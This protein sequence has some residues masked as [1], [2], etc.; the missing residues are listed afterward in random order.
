MRSSKTFLYL[1]LILLVSASTI[2]TVLAQDG[3][4][5]PY[6]GDIKLQQAWY[7]Q[8]GTYHGAFDYIDGVID[9][10]PWLPFTVVAC[11]AGTARY[12][13]EVNDPNNSGKGN[14]VSLIFQLG[15]HSYQMKYCHLESSPLPE[16]PD[17]VVVL[18]QALG[19]TGISGA[20]NDVNHLHYL[21]YQ[22]GV[23]FDPYGIASGEGDVKKRDS[24]WPNAPLGANHIFATNP[25]SFVPIVDVGYFADGWHTDGKSQAILDCFIANGGY[26]TFGAP[27]DKGHSPYAYTL[28]N[29][30][31]AQDFDKAGHWFQIIYNPAPSVEKAYSVHGQILTF[32]EANNGYVNYGPPFTNEI[33]KKLATGPEGTV[34]SFAQPGDDLIYQ[35]F[36]DPNGTRKTIAFNTRTGQTDHY[37]LATFGFNG[38]SDIQWFIQSTGG[39]PGADVAWP[40]ILQ[41]TPTG[42]WVTVP[43]WY[44]FVQH[45]N[46]APDGNRFGG[47]IAQLHE[48]NNQ[49]ADPSGGTP[50]PSPAPVTNL[51]TSSV[52][53]S[54]VTLT[55]TD[56]NY[57][58]ASPYQVSRDG[59]VIGTSSITSYQDN[60]VATGRIYS[61]SVSVNNGPES[62]PITVSVPVSGD[63]SGGY[64][65]P[66]TRPRYTL[67]STP[68]GARYRVYEGGQTGYMFEGTTPSFIP[69]LNAGMT[70]RIEYLTFDS[71]WDTTFTTVEGD[72]KVISGKL[73]TDPF[74]GNLLLNHSFDDATIEAPWY[75]N[76]TAQVQGN[77]ADGPYCCMVRIHQQGSPESVW[78]RQQIPV[79]RGQRLL[80][81][82]YVRQQTG[83]GTGRVRLLGSDGTTSLGWENGE[84]PIGNTWKY[85]VYL[86]MQV[87]TASDEEA[88]FSFEIGNNVPQ[89][90]YFDRV[91]VKEDV[92][93]KIVANGGFE[94]GITMPWIV[95][96]GNPS[97]VNTPGEAAEGGYCFSNQISTAGTKESVSLSQRIKL[98]NGQYYKVSFWGKASSNRA[99]AV[100]CAGSE[101]SMSLST[102]W[103]EFNPVFLMPQSGDSLSDVQFLMGDV[104]STV[105][106]DGIAVD[107]TSVLPPTNL[108]A[109]GTFETGDL[110]GW[111]SYSESGS[112]TVQNGGAAEG[113]YCSKVTVGST[114][115]TWDASISQRIPVT[116][117]EPRTVIFWGKA[118]S[119]R[120]VYINLTQYGGAWAWY[121]WWQEVPLTTNWQRFSFSL[122]P[123]ATDSNADFSIQCGDQTATV[124]I[125]SVAVLGEGSNPTPPPSG[126]NLL[127]NAGFESGSFSPWD[128]FSDSGTATV[129]NATAGEGTYSAKFTVNTAGNTWDASVSHRIPVEANVSYIV[130][131]RAKASSNR[132]VYI[133]LTE[134][135]GDWTWYGWW[136]EVPVTTVWQE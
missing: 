87:V 123:N 8:D 43:G 105:Y 60:A 78:L 49:F 51:A 107:T 13:R 4:Y 34:W 31:T 38:T 129:T 36:G 104:V 121:G 75:A 63:G 81:G 101:Q 52:T 106:L 26:T 133:N 40:K 98:K 45:E 90:Y 110:S 124:W 112:V 25:P 134:Y 95:S 56:P 6:S 94:S 70:I 136:Q 113:D 30:K 128:G 29:G 91:V 17:V 61:Y 99:L 84:F 16:G 97:F 79:I 71:S 64:N 11:H 102:A 65:D 15:G 93:G 122:T 109:N 116:A 111:D 88:L 86:P 119:N 44:N 132:M 76:S 72:T 131:L 77:A 35:K 14:W 22:D 73:T 12:T 58:T 39:N 1:A 80:V 117:N 47:L 21:I 115:N 85:P 54:S 50:P 28:P 92:S 125:D 48:G 27:A 19:I 118:S 24:Y 7:Y 55:W 68:S 57:S 20:A 108:V 59:V 46:D 66:D 9:N 3:I 100:K 33:L 74:S 67:F 18:G 130:N 5:L 82:F 135:L 114:G 53:S 62:S 89:D 96:G 2:Q 42:V 23:R 126:A 32:L 120:T 41:L 10:S 103:Q 127:S 83:V 37:P 69:P